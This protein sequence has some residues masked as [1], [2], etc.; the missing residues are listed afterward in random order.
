M[1]TDPETAM[2]SISVIDFLDDGNAV[3]RRADGSEAMM[4]AVDLPELLLREQRVWREANYAVLC[5][6]RHSGGAAYDGA[7]TTQ[8]TSG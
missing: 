8:E 6:N 3:V 2:P 7:P 1:S 4:M 5:S